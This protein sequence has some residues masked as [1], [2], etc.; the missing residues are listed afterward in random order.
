MNTGQSMLTLGAIM[1]LSFITLRINA[2][3]IQA[4]GGI[5]NAKFGIL[6]TSLATSMMER[7]SRLAFDDASVD[8]DIT[9]TSS[10]TAW[11]AL[12]PETGETITT[13]DDIDDYNNYSF[14][15]SSLPSAVF[16]IQCSVFYVNPEVSLSTLTS[17]STY[18]KNF[19]VAVSSVSMKDTIRLSSIYSYWF[20]R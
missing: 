8:I 4:Q 11:N 5:Q 18:H 15:E 6:A 7:A 3:I 20:F 9:T 14:I 1:M 17:T 19:T 13:Y 16:K 2:N 10:L 12:G